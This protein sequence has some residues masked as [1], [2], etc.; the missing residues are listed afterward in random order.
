MLHD[1][2]P[3]YSVSHNDQI[4]KQ[5]VPKRCRLSWLTNSALVYEPKC[6]GGGGSLSEWEQLYTGAQIKFGYLTPYLTY[7]HKCRCM[8]NRRHRTALS[9][10][11]KKITFMLWLI[12]ILYILV[13]NMHSFYCV[14]RFTVL[15]LI[16]LGSGTYQSVNI[17]NEK[18]CYKFF[19]DRGNT[20]YF[21]MIFIRSMSSYIFYR[22]TL[23]LVKKYK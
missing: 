12:V 4:S 17:L 11:N 15:S 18:H 6:R 10:F 5:G 9:S 16:I 14:I 13:C 23:P 2:I 20:R 21:F 7:D 19:N 1:R 3:F 8:L 22:A